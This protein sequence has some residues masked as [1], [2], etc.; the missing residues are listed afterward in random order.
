MDNRPVSKSEVEQFIGDWFRKLDIHPPIADLLRF[1]ADEKLVMNMSER[2]FHHHEGFAEWYRGVARFRNQSHRVKALEMDLEHD[3]AT[4]KMIVRWE[5][6]DELGEDP[7]LRQ[8]F[9][10][11]QTWLLE[12]SPQTRDLFIVMY[13]VDYFLKCLSQ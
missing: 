9:Y 4:V 6:T 13:T 5:R 3:R 2:Q 11:A 8:A 1:L 12:R 10:A 7:A